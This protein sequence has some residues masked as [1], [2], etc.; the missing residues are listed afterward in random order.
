MKVRFAHL[1]RRM[2][3]CL[4]LNR[5]GRKASCLFTTG[6][7]AAFGIP[8]GPTTEYLH[9][10]Q[11]ESPALTPGAFVYPTCFYCTLVNERMLPRP[12]RLMRTSLSAVVSVEIAK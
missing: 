8:A 7:R 11:R 4:N 12:P 5:C 3:T 9:A 6:H 2:T 10:P 1:S